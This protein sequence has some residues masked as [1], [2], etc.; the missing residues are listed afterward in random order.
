[1]GEHGGLASHAN[2]DQQ[3]LITLRDRIRH[4]EYEVNATAVAAAILDRLLGGG[5]LRL[6]RRGPD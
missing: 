3:E 1:M 6:D 5:L 2:H 4:G